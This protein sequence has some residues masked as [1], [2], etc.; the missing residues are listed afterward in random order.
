M[1][2]SAGR[3]FEKSDRPTTTV[4][5]AA[6]TTADTTERATFWRLLDLA[7]KRQDRLNDIVKVKSA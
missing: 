4:R 2:D 3:G 7:P 1:P 5:A 6:S